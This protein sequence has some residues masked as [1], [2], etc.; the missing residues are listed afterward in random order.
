MRKET[1]RGPRWLIPISVAYPGGDF[2]TENA[3]RPLHW[4]EPG[5]RKRQDTI[6][7]VS[8]PYILNVNQTGYYR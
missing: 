8:R 2:D 6:K 4:M 5:N 7:I 1:R 3:T